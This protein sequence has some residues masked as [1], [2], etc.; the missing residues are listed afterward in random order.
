MIEQLIIL[1]NH[2]QGTELNSSLYL[3]LEQGLRWHRTCKT[4]DPP[5]RHCR[6]VARIHLTAVEEED[7]ETMNVSSEHKVGEV[8]Q[9]LVLFFR[10]KI[11]NP[12]PPT[13]SD[14]DA[15]L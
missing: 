5:H 6:D 7:A 9:E 12:P 8:E 10:L 15:A 13:T 4:P 3:E 11:Q 1:I 2:E 14:F